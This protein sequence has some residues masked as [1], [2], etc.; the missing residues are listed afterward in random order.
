M[1]TLSKMMGNFKILAKSLLHF[2]FYTSNLGLKVDVVEV[3]I[4][5]ELLG[6]VQGACT[7]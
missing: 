1:G 4:Y 3:S 6:L 5:S 2:H 7:D